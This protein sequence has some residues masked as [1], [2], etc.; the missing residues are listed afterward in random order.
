MNKKYRNCASIFLSVTLVVAA[1]SILLIVF[2]SCRFSVN[3]DSNSANEIGNLLSAGLG[4]IGIAIAVWAALNITNAISRGEIEKA[5]ETVSDLE[6]KIDPIDKFIQKNK[7][8]QVELFL[9][10]ITRHSDDPIIGY[11]ESQSNASQQNDP[12]AELT[13]IES[14]FYRVK[15]LHKSKFE[16]DSVL[17]EIAK[18]GLANIEALGTEECSDFVKKYLCYRSAGFNF[19]MGYCAENYLAG[20]KYF[21]EALEK[22]NESAKY[23]G[24]SLN[25]DKEPPDER[26]RFIAAALYNSVG[27]SYSKIVHYYN[28]D[29]EGQTK[30]AFQEDIAMY[31]ERAVTYLTMAIKC[32]ERISSCTRSTTYRNLGC[33]YERKDKLDGKFGANK[34]NIISSYKKALA[35]VWDDSPTDAAMVKNAYHTLLSYYC[36]FITFTVS[37]GKTETFTNLNP[38]ELCVNKTTDKKDGTAITEIAEMYNY[39]RLAMQNL[40][41]SQSI[42]QFYVASCCFAAMSKWNGPGADSQLDNNQPF[43]IAEAKQ[44]NEKYE[45][46]FCRGSTAKIAEKF[47]KTITML[48]DYIVKS[49]V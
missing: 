10:E 6:Q 38:M 47:N 40:P 35:H 5:R 34:D 31:S 46:L 37:E 30:N 16:T 1:I 3:L 13:I 43:Y 39:A 9:Q 12:Y 7:G 45:M 48:C 32:E 19:Y 22:Y 27:E 29:L 26:D 14:L 44:F 36:K 15:S 49:T 18:K 8:V 23:F 41:G 42:T 20:A 21:K 24:I 25:P 28:D 11:L 4:I 17:L 33:A 2:F